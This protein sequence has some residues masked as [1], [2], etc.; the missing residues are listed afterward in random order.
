MME[1]KPIIRDGGV[2]HVTLTSTTDPYTSLKSG[3]RGVLLREFSDSV[4]VKWEDG[5]SLKLIRYEDH[6]TESW[7]WEL[8]T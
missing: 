5:S 4:L 3:S 7:P 1:T 8:G 6:W 2:V